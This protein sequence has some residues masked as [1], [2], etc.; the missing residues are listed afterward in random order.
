MGANALLVLD[1]AMAAMNAAAR[2]QQL[3]VQMQVDGR[4]DID[5]GDLMRLTQQ[6]NDLQAKWKAAIGK[7]NEGG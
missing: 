7:V 4:D 3:L 1:I 2:A 6:T 5:A